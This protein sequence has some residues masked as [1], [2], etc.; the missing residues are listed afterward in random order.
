MNTSLQ[1]SHLIEATNAWVV[2]HR[3]EIV[4]TLADLVRIPSVIGNEAPAQAFMQQ[5]YEAL[6]LE[7]DA[8]EP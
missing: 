7:V 4:Q 6:G 2:A 3:D 5:H 1:F 8:F